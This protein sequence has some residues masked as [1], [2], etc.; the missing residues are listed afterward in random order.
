MFV[1]TIYKNEPLPAFTMDVTK[2]LAL[3]QKMFNP[4]LAEAIRQLS[5]LKYG[6]DVRLVESE[7]ATRSKL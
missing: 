5:R 3:E 4:K 7:I 1:K 6:K 2:D